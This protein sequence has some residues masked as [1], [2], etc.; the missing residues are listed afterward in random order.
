ME[1]ILISGTAEEIAKGIQK[2]LDDHTAK[3][4]PEP[5]PEPKDDRVGIDEI[6]LLTGLS[7]SQ[8]YKL[9]MANA[10]PHRKFGRRLV[11][12]VKAITE[13]MELQ[14]TGKE[15]NKQKAARELAKSAIK[16]AKNV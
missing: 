6:K 9:T 2:I 7:L 16:R 11:F 8:L 13:W 15:T 5:A 12:S 3:F 10:I 14:T 4:A 1:T